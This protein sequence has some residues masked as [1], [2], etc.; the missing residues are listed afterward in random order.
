MKAEYL[1]EV[2][3]D[4]EQEK[5][6]KTSIKKEKAGTS[7]KGII[8]TLIAGLSIIIC[9]I[10]LT[11]GFI[12]YKGKSGSSGITASGSA[13]C[14]F[15]S[16]LIV[17]RGSFSAFG[18]TSDAAYRII[19]KDAD[20][21]KEYLEENGI[22]EEEMV[23]SSVTI[24]R[25]YTSIYS[26]YGDYI[27][28]ELNGYNLYQDVCITSSDVDKVEQISRDIS[29]LIESGIE[30]A[31]ESPEYYYTKLDELKLQLIEDATANAKQRVDIIAEGTGA[32]LG[33]LSNANLGVFQITARNSASEEYSYG[34]TF[35]TSSRE[36]TATITVRLNYSV[37]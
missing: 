17:W 19:K 26:D 2:I 33:N 25:D 15:E 28:E 22:K 11:M 32:T 10:I 8:I 4:T 37:K 12:S 7:S 1:G 9:T 20:A 18:T 29:G 3:M 5:V 27:G 14:D 35:N 6:E 34:G 21:V 30:F 13:N 16:D 23:F 31:S 24:N 36:K